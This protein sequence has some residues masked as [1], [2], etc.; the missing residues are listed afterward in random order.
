MLAVLAVLALASGCAQTGAGEDAALPV[1]SL[2]GSGQCGG[3]ERPAA[4]WIA[5]GAEW[6]S[7]YERIIRPQMNPP[8]PP[9]VDF[10]RDGVLLV[11]M[12]ARPSA[13]YGLS[14]AT[15]TAAVAV[16][17][18]VLSLRVDWREPPPGYRQAQVMTSPCLLLKVPAVPFAR[19]TVL[20]PEGRVRLEGAR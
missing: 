14:L 15:G 4:I 16:R 19:I 11:A 6:R 10:S 9:T 8:S 5:S 7:W 1:A 2:Y 12:G 18:G 3:L 17:D 20:D 13:G